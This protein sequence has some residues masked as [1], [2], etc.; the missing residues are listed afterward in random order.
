MAQ[1]PKSRGTGLE[2]MIAIPMPELECLWQAGRQADCLL[3]FRPRG[4]YVCLVASVTVLP[5]L[6]K[7]ILQSTQ[8]KQKKKKKAG[9]KLGIMA[10]KHMQVVKEVG[11]V[12]AGSDWKFSSPRAFGL[13]KMPSPW[14]MGYRT[15][16]PTFFTKILQKNGLYSATV[17]AQAH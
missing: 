13:T 10:T 2:Y 9:K 6:P 8:S 15:S 1:L 14:A 3:P 11:Y 17:V 4:L 16:P 12:R 7:Q 5:C